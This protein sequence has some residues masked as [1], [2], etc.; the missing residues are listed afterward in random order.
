MS[1]Q[2]LSEHSRLPTHTLT[3]TMQAEKHVHSLWGHPTVRKE[4][5][6]KWFVYVKLFLWGAKRFCHLHS[7]VRFSTK[8]LPR[9]G[10]NYPHSSNS[11]LRGCPSH[12]AT[13]S[14]DVYVGT[15]INEAPHTHKSNTVIRANTVNWQK[16]CVCCCV[17]VYECL[18]AAHI[19][20]AC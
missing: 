20:R 19:V 10:V 17:G 15:Q 14:S 16:C 5:S 4:E 13:Y 12:V 3:R 11:F 9:M 1:A 18:L 8:L 6:S 2:S 7:M